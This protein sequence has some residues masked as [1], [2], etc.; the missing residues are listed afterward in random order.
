MCTF[1]ITNN[2]NK[3]WVDDY[4]SLG[5]P[6]LSNSIEIGGIYISHHLLNVTGE[7]TPQPVEKDGLYFIL[8]GEIYNYDTSLP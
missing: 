2:P 5:G 7:I 4:L 1:K 3:T 6:T 8:M